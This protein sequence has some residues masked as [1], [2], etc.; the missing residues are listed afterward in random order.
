MNHKNGSHSE[1]RKQENLDIMVKT[2]GEAF[3]ENCMK[4][5]KAAIFC[6]SHDKYYIWKE[7]AAHMNDSIHDIVE[8]A[9]RMPGFANLC[10][11]DQLVLVKQG[12]FPVWVITQV[13]CT[14]QTW[15]Q[16]INIGKAGACISVKQ[17]NILYPSTLCERLVKLVSTMKSLNMSDEEAALLSCLALLPPS[18]MTIGDHFS[19]V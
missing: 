9:K 18:H 17:L 6:S 16:Q 19:T 14:T 10:H 8:F 7:F 2:A 5:E 4:I 13:V 1:V 15:P 12:S 11:E 3:K